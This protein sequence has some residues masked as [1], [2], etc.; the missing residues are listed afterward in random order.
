MFIR[1]YFTKPLYTILVLPF[2]TLVSSQECVQEDIVFDR[3]N[4]FYDGFDYCNYTSFR[5]VAQ[6]KRWYWS[7]RN[8]IDKDLDGNGKLDPW[9]NFE[10]QEI[11]T[12]FGKT[13]NSCLKIESYR[14]IEYNAKIAE[15]AP[16]LW[17]E[18]WQY[19]S[20]QIIQVLQLDIDPNTSV[21][22]LA[23]LYMT[24]RDEALKIIKKIEPWW[25]ER[26]SR[27][28]NDN[29]NIITHNDISRPDY[30]GQT[31][32]INN[33]DYW[34]NY[35]VYIPNEKDFP[36]D[37]ESNPETFNGF[38][39]SSTKKIFKKN[40]SV[41]NKR[42]GLR[43][44]LEDIFE[45]VSKTNKTTEETTVFRSAIPNYW[46]T[47]SQE[48]NDQKG[49]DSIVKKSGKKS[50]AI[51]KTKNPS[52]SQWF[53][54]N[55]PVSKPSKRFF[56]Q[57]W[58]KAENVSDSTKLY[59]VYLNV[60]FEDGSRKFVYKNLGFKTGTH[61]WEKT[62]DT[63]TFNKDVV[64]K[65]PFLM[66]HGGIGNVWFDD[67][68]IQNLEDNKTEILPNK[69]FEAMSE[70]RKNVSYL[71][72]KKQWETIFVNMKK[73]IDFTALNTKGKK[74][75]L[76]TPFW[77]KETRA[78]YPQKGEYE[79]LVNKINQY[80]K[81]KNVT[82]INASNILSSHHFSHYILGDNKDKIDVLHFNE[83]GHTL[84]ARYIA[85]ELGL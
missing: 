55:I 8:E 52:S 60:S 34:F 3:S 25:D 31:N 54:A 1:K 5:E 73:L 35:A 59:C 53:G 48:Y 2:S 22:N 69:S 43:T 10:R 45:R 28:A 36:F 51:K 81:E 50:L 68:S 6:D 62:E 32:L 47:Q 58:S 64:S 75:F 16:A 23:A 42:V 70:N 13:N 21:A 61:D 33:K 17:T 79:T 67:V 66:F 30:T 63:L 24:Q 65:R 78:G 72:N 38:L 82:F 18:I 77:Q 7:T 74:A 11:I 84:L 40:I 20:R 76:L 12:D 39:N 19:N 29:Y 4:Y 83:D 37:L 46:Q 27:T 49:W 57:A 56:V 41:Y 26:H 80:C 14:P 85:F 9:E 15:Y 44:W 71:Y